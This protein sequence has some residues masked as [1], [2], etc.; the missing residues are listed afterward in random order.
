MTALAHYRRDDLTLHIVK[1]AG[2]WDIDPYNDAE[3]V[4]T[5][6]AIAPDLVVIHVQYAD[7]A[8]NDVIL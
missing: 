7:R 4:V 1:T 8:G 5:I 2:A 6:P 3:S